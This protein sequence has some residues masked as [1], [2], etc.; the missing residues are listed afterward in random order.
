MPKKRL[1]RAPLRIPQ[2]VEDYLQ[3]NLE[4]DRFLSLRQRTKIIKQKFDFPMYPMRLRD[5]FLRN[6]IEYKL[7]KTV[8]KAALMSKNAR[9]KARRDFALQFLSLVLQKKKVWIADETSVRITVACSRAK[10]VFI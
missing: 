7:C 10:C 8:P 6:N 3:N 2:D 4:E 5:Y 9:Q 1:G